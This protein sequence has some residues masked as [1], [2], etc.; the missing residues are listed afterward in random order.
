MKHKNFTLIILALIGALLFSLLTVYA[1]AE[2]SR[3]LQKKPSVS[4]RSAALYEPTTKQFLF[5]KNPD[6]RL[7]MA[8]TTKIM[9]A[10][11]ALEN[12]DLQ[13]YVKIDERAV[14]VEGS[15]AYLKANEIIPLEELI[16]AL[17]LQSANDAA[18]SIA[19]HISGDIQSFAALMNEKAK[20]IGLCDTNFENPHGLDSDNHY[21]TARDLAII[22]AC[23]LEKPFLRTV[24][25]TYK[26][27]FKS[28]GRRRTYVNHNKLLLRIDGAVGLKTGFTKKSGRCLVGAAER[29]NLM[30]ISVTLDAPNDWNDH[31]AM[32]NCGFST[33]EMVK[34]I[35]KDELSF[36]IPVINSQGRTL[37]VKC[38]D[39]VAKVM[40]K[41]A[42]EIK[43]H[44]K[45]PSILVAPI[46]RG[47]TVGTVIVTVDG[48]K[49]AEARLIAEHDISAKEK[50][51]LLS[52]IFK[53]F[54]NIKDDHK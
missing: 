40:P 42:R 15:S 13:D 20:A 6:E 51:G 44:V 33:L 8:S 32:L 50:E 5:T 23:A 54:I 34:L 46:K 16:Y 39:D 1:S 29:D 9:T 31:E 38:Q 37:I 11:V 3:A 24:C 53:R 52:R 2:G 48:E 7:P 43:Q 49:T 30:L 27:T 21:T 22:A 41:Q 25:S 28:E 17:M 19:Y 35:D 47:D 26:K 18:E 4:A 36:D 12:A 45:L 10:I 14:G